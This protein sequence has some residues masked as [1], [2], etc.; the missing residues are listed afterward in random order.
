MCQETRRATGTDPVSCGLE[1]GH[2]YQH[3]LE[4][5]GQRAV[6]EDPHNKT[7]YFAIVIV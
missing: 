6:Y 5:S 3:G 1:T 4:H 7:T 2:I